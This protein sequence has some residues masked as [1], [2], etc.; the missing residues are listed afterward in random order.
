MMPLR[1]ERCRSRKAKFWDEKMLPYQV[2]QFAGELPPFRRDEQHPGSPPPGAK[3]PH[4]T[5]NPSLPARAVEQGSDA[6]MRK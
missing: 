3:H 5:D 6:C 4:R 1:L 2:P